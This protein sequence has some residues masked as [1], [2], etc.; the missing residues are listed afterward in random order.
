MECEFSFGSRALD[1]AG[2]GVSEVC[3]NGNTDAVHPA[4][5]HSCVC[6]RRPKFSLLY[7]NVNSAKA[8]WKY[9]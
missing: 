7:S 9:A 3:R 2:S 6:S 4:E 8:K 1:S 5:V